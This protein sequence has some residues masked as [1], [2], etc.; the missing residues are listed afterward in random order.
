MDGRIRLWRRSRH[1]EINL[2]IKI[3]TN[4][5]NAF[6]LM[7]ES[8]NN[9]YVGSC[10]NLEKRINKHNAGKCRY[11]SGRRPWKLIYF[12]EY[13]TRSEAMKREKFLKSG[14]GRKF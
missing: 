1:S 4:M 7:S 2:P 10:E 5:Y 11:T 14:Q 13:N 6:V 12:E 3:K 9:R 8:H